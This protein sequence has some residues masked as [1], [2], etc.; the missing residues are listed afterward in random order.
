MYLCTPNLRRGIEQL[1]ARRAHNPEVAGSSPAPATTFIKRKSL[2]IRDFLCFRPAPFRFSSCTGK[3]PK[4][5][6]V[7]MWNGFSRMQDQPVH[8][9]RDFSAPECPKKQYLSET[10]NPPA[11][12][13]STRPGIQTQCFMPGFDF[14]IITSGYGTVAVHFN[15]EHS[16]KSVGFELQPTLF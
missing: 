14:Y 13:P 8:H 4:I 5:R 7:L 15:A 11:L 10:P 9:C 6:V 16:S 12:N 2:I 1:V 3:P